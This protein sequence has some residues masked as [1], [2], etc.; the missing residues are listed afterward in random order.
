MTELEQMIDRDEFLKLV[1]DV[2]KEEFGDEEITF[3]LT[4]E[5]CADDLYSGRNPLPGARA[6]AGARAG[7]SEIGAAETVWTGLKFVLFMA[8]LYR[9]I[10]AWPRS[11]EESFDRGAFATELSSVLSGLGLPSAVADMVARKAAGWLERRSGKGGTGS[12]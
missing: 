1:R 5:A 11:D 7:V 2:V 3:E 12:E 8:G 9:V 10:K 4:G 6:A